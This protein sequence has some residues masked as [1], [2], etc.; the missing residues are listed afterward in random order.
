MNIITLIILIILQFIVLILFD[1]I[2]ELE[3]KIRKNT[4]NIGWY[5]GRVDFVD[6]EIKRLN[7]EITDEEF[8]FRLENDKPKNYEDIK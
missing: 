5:Q 3:H 2:I 4:Y 6:L 8:Y 7:K 1:L